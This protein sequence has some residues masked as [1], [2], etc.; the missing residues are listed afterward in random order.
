M[1][2]KS[3]KKG[4]ALPLLFLLPFRQRLLQIIQRLKNLSDLLIHFAPPQICV[5]DECVDLIQGGHLVVVLDLRLGAVYG[6]R[7]DIE[8]EIE[9]GSDVLPIDKGHIRLDDAG[10]GKHLGYGPQRQLIFL[11]APGAGAVGQGVIESPGCLPGVGVAGKPADYRTGM[12]GNGPGVAVVQKLEDHNVGHGVPLFHR[13]P[14][15]GA[16][17]AHINGNYM[18][19]LHKITSKSKIRHTACHPYT[20]KRE[21]LQLHVQL[22]IYFW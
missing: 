10:H 16:G 1:L 4:A 14:G 11:R 22:F 3:I 12:D 20:Q 5:G 18:G 13:N 9:G 2:G 7:V 8:L 6:S 19:H 17:I 15:G 21:K